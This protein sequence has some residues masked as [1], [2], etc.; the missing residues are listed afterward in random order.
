MSVHAAGTGAPTGPEGLP[1]YSA[2]LRAPGQAGTVVALRLTPL[3]APAP[4]P[5]P[6]HWPYGLLTRIAVPM[7]GRRWHI[8]D[9]ADAVHVPAAE[10]AEVYG[11]LVD[12]YERLGYTT[13]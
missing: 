6:D 2:V 5:D 4:A 11:A 8:T 13:A 7:D 1:V 9:H 10:A 3:P 12:Q